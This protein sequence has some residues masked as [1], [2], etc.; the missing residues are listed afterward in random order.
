MAHPVQPRVLP[1]RPYQLRRLDDQASGEF[2]Q[3]NHCRIPPPR[4]SVVLMDGL[5]PTVDA[6]GIQ[7][8]VLGTLAAFDRANSI[9]DPDANFDSINRRRPMA[10]PRLSFAASRAI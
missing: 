3:H 4:S 2:I 9:S 8:R 7:K 1:T 6:P 10:I 5:L